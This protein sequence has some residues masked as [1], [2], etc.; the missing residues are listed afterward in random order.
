MSPSPAATI[1]LTRAAERPDRRLEFHR[2]LPTAARHKM[3]DALLRDGL[4]AE[5]QDEYRLGEG[6]LLIES[7]ATGLMLTTLALTDAGFPA[8]D[9]AHTAP[10]AVPHGNLRDAAAAVLAAW[11]NETNSETD[12]I[13]ALAVP[14]DALRSALAT[15]HG[16]TAHG[17]GAPRKP[18]EGTKQEGVLTMQRR[19]EGATVAQI[20]EATGWVS[21]TVRGFLPGLKKK[22]I[23]VSTLER[24]RIVG[25]NRDGR[26]VLLR[27][28]RSLADVAAS[29]LRGR[30]GWSDCSA[31]HSVRPRRLPLSR[32]STRHAKPAAAQAGG[33]D[34]HASGC[35]ARTSG[36][37]CG[38]VRTLRPNGSISAFA[39]CAFWP[40]STAVVSFG[41]NGSNVRNDATPV[42]SSAAVTLRVP[43]HLCTTFHVM[44]RLRG[45]PALIMKSKVA[46]AVG[47][48]LL[49][50]M[51][52]DPRPPADVIG[53]GFSN[54]NRMSASIPP[55]SGSKSGNSQSEWA[56]R[57]PAT[58][59][60]SRNMWGAA[61]IWRRAAT[62]ACERRDRATSSATAPI[63]AT[64]S[65]TAVLRSSRHS[66][67]LLQGQHATRPAS[68]CCARPHPRL[69]SEIPPRHLYIPSARG[70][71]ADFR[72]RGP[73]LS[74]P[75]G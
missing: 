41:S 28:T 72:L 52:P 50:E 10:V 16:R 35:D 51:K 13:A 65:S 62:T 11:M 75:L 54:R 5:T 3:I 14:M 56:C 12:I 63:I 30:A 32:G 6:A 18:R 15:K 57:S 42:C 1:V 59:C 73:G 39:R 66:V 58:N 64:Q 29:T 34:R 26:K 2:K 24:V 68:I 45:S 33:M 9:V 37:G 53:Q 8:L 48:S 27:S 46:S 74:R 69:R 47:S 60:A 17:P 20:A 7:S 61:S 44:V 36:D 38:D 43:F 40:T 67:L 70:R 4:I 31:P 22:G 25:P 49:R 19:A 23:E 21:H 71:L 55:S